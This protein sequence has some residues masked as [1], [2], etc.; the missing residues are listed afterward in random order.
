V[1]EEGRLATVDLAQVVE[2]HNRL[3]RVLAEG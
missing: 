2:L 1:V 3:A